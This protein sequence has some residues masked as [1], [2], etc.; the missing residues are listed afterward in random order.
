MGNHA[1]QHTSACSN[2][3]DRALAGF[4]DLLTQLVVIM[5]SSKDLDR[6]AFHVC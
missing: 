5:A 6:C 3:H 4:K 2:L 1:C